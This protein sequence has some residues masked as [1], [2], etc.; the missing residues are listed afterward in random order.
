[1]RSR[2]N[3]TGKGFANMQPSDVGSH[4]PSTTQAITRLLILL[5]MLGPGG[6]A[7][8]ESEKSFLPKAPE[9]ILFH[10]EQDDE[11]ARQIDERA[12]IE[13]MYEVAAEKIRDSGYTMHVELSDFRT[14]Y[15]EAFDETLWS[16]MISRPDGR[17]L[18]GQRT[19]F[20]VEQDGQKTVRS[21]REVA[22]ETKSEIKSTL[23]E[24]GL[25]ELTVEQ[26]LGLYASHPRAE[27]NSMEK[28][29]KAPVD[30]ESFEGGNADAIRAL[31]TYQA[32][33]Q[34][35]ADTVSYRAVALWELGPDGQVLANLQDRVFE[36]VGQ[37]V[38]EGTLSTPHKSFEAFR[39]DMQRQPSAGLGG[40]WNKSIKGKAGVDIELKLRDP[41]DIDPIIR[42]RTEVVDKLS[43]FQYLRDSTG[44]ATGNHLAAF[45]LISRFTCHENCDVS[46]QPLIYNNGCNDG[47]TYEGLLVTGHKEYKVLD[48]KSSTASKIATC[49]AGMQCAVKE[50]IVFVCGSVGVNVSIAGQSVTFGAATNALWKANMSDS[51]SHTCTIIPPPM[52][53]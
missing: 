29:L 32:T 21:H 45:D 38:S 13:E 28:S 17:K 8:Q 11:L 40:G 14:L 42:C 37:F 34:Y 9:M 49:T 22:W 43:P 47:G 1:M 36:S 26:A 2:Q 52:C 3:T 50:C 39:A 15:P 19:D 44:H 18:R 7:A 35:E 5:M 30:S 6:I 51:T 10:G 41:G 20:V 46:C 23:A 12:V 25:T 33:L 27:S 16:D 48:Q 4:T 24:K 31:T 53:T